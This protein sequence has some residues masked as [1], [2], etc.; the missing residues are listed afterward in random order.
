[1]ALP[2]SRLRRKLSDD[3]DSD[4]ERWIINIYNVGYRLI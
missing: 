3:G 2:P 4:S 1:V